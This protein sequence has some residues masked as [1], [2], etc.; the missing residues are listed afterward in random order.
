MNLIVNATADYGGQIS[1]KHLGG[2]NFEFE[3]RQFYDSQGVVPNTVSLNFISP[4]CSISNATLNKVSAQ[5]N[6]NN[7]GPNLAGVA[8]YRGIKTIPSTCSNF[9]ITYST[10]RGNMF[11]NLN[12]GH[13]GKVQLN[14]YD[15]IG[16]NSS[17][18]FTS[19]PIINIFTGE[20]AILN[21]SAI[22][23]DGDSLFYRFS[24][25]PGSSFKSGF[26]SISQFGNFPSSLNNFT[27]AL[28]VTA[29][30]T[31]GLYLIAIEVMEYRGNVLKSTSQRQ[32]AIWVNTNT[33]N[34]HNPTITGINATSNFNTS[35]CHGAVLNFYAVINDVDNDPI[36]AS[37]SSPSFGTTMTRSNDTLYFRR[38]IDSSFANV[39]NL[40]LGVKLDD[41]NCGIINQVFSVK[42]N[43]CIATGIIENKEQELAVYPNPANSFLLLEH[44]ASN[45]DVHVLDI[46]GKI[47]IKSLHYTSKDKI[48]LTNIPNGIY[49]LTILNTKNNQ[50]ITKK[51]V[52]AR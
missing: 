42:I 29:P 48:N 44:T 13:L 6:S 46:T 26:S 12:D 50:R 7:C 4:N 30:N 27:G 51:F 34:N 22:E 37:L 49:F 20:T 25:V 32:I 41:G 24:T 9:Q 3:Y 35:L 36:I 21:F 38:V 16:G 2:N 8:I 14:I 15:S 28:S 40:S 47:L 45:V 19:T 43:P 39:K 18:V 10:G 5:A 23:D 52:V 17:P 31:Q 1:Y 33:Q 11:S